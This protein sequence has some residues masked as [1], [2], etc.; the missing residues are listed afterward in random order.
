M[1]W[2]WTLEH[3]VLC[4]GL[5]Q[6][7]TPIL[8]LCFFTPLQAVLAAEVSSH[9]GRATGVGLPQ[10]GLRGGSE[11]QSRG[12]GSASSQEHEALGSWVRLCGV[13][14]EPRGEPR[15]VGQ[16]SG[17]IIPPGRPPAGCSCL[18]FQVGQ[19]PRIPERPGVTPQRVQAG[20]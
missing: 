9:P 16:R 17:E 11:G 20:S 4:H 8:L 12:R 3:R 18:L 15:G 13:A 2:T 5:N 7:V 10:T 1:A 14:Q 6:K 19:M